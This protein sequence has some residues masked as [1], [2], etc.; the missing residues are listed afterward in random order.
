[1]GVATG[2][3]FST[4]ITIDRH[5]TTVPPWQPEGMNIAMV[6]LG[7]MGANMVRRLQRAGH[8][9]V[10]YDVNPDAVA[11]AVADGATG[12]HS[13]TELVDALEAPRHV[14]IMVPAAYVGNTVDQ[15]AE[16]L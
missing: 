16:L 3:E 13:L 12:A 9:C 15:L 8:D 6:G 5:A 11:A 1:M 14:W 4:Q 2:L 7:R 10:A